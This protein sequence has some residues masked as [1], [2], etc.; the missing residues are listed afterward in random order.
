MDSFIIECPE[1]GIRLEVDRKTGKIINKFPKPNINNSKDPLMD[2]IKKTKESKENLDNYFFRSKEEMDKKK[3][4]LEKHFEDAKK[5]AK[6]DPTKPINP[7]D[8]D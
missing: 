5:K 3:K 4:E 8:L 1:C 7:M 2:M 6:D